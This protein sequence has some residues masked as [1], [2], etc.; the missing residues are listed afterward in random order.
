MGLPF[1][2]ENFIMVENRFNSQLMISAWKFNRQQARRK[3][4]FQ[5]IIYCAGRNLSDEGATR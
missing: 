4:Y 3:S 5:V 1:F 2:M